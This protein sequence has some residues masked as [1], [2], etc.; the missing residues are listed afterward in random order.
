LRNTL[1]ERIEAALLP[2]LSGKSEHICLLDP[3]GHPNVGD[4]TILLGELDLLAR[5]FPDARLSF[6]DVDSYSPA[7][8]PFIDE[9][10]ILVIHGGGN[11]GDIWPHH[12]DLRMRILR[13]FAHKRIVQLPQSIHFDSAAALQAT[14]ATIK[15]HPDFTLMVRDRR[16]F[17]FASR[18]FECPVM[19]APDMA[20]AMRPIVRAPPSVDYFCL[21]RTDKEAV[22]DQRPVVE[23]LQEWSSSVETGD[24]LDERRNFSTRLDRSLRWRAKAQP[25]TAA[26]LRSTIVRLRR[27]YA[28]Q[29][30]NYGIGLL[31]RGATVVTDRLHAHILCCL[32]DIPHLIFDSYDRKISAFYETWTEDHAAARL[33]ASAAELA[34]TRSPPVLRGDLARPRPARRRREPPATPGRR[35]TRVGFPWFRGRTGGHR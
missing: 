30:L 15:A 8:D 32:L 10:S 2:L 27:H 5:S 29:R 14:A 12:H 9:A 18:H 13:R 20:F 34:A 22:I 1:N 19:L 4:N 7:A 33:F 25:A 11:F 35:R 26:R 31:S 28:M 23:R 17:D 6:Y 24:W 3:P 16:S 21:F